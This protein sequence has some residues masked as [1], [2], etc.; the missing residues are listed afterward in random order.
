MNL[1]WPTTPE[2]PPLGTDDLHVWAVRL[3][4]A[5]APWA[6]QLAVLAADER[7]RA[8]RF[9]VED[10]RRRFVLSRYALRTQLAHYLSFP[11]AEIVFNYDASGKPRLANAG[12]ATGLNFNLAHSDDLALVAITRGCAVGVDVEQLRDVQHWPEIAERYFH[13]TEVAE[14]NALDSGER[15]A[16]FMR[17]WTAKEAILKALG[18]GITQALDFLVGA[19]PSHSGAWIDTPTPAGTTFARCWLQSLEPAADYG[20]A[21]ACLGQE[22]R[23]RCFT[24]PRGGASS[25]PN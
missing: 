22:R 24:A 15:A 23:V 14:I 13:P 11:A 25:T 4:D 10:A 5:R 3:D 20:G 12:G 19:G 16:A 17:C 2:P 6:M 8:E 7:A 9:R 1:H 21:V 18:T